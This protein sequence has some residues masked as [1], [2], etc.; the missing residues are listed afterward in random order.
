MRSLFFFL[1]AISINCV[2]QDI[3]P[4]T[5]GPEYV[6]YYPENTFIKRH[7][8]KYVIDSSESITSGKCRLRM[9]DTLGRIIIDNWRPDAPLDNPFIYREA[10]DTTYRLKYNSDKS[11][12]IAYERFVHNKKGQIVSYLDCANYYFKDNSYYVQYEAFYYD[13]NNILQTRLSYIREEFPGKVADQANVKPTDLEL[14][15]VINYS[16]RTLKNGHKLK[17]GKHALGKPDWRATDTTIFD[18]QNRMIR[19]NSFSKRGVTG[20]LIRNLLNNITV[21]QYTDSTLKITGY[22]T[23]C[24]FFDEQVGCLGSLDESHKDEELFIYNRDKL[25]RARYMNY[26]S[27]EPFL[28]DKYSYTYY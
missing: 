23:F 13:E 17:I 21:Y 26:I 6:K 20:E 3:D 25:P 15:D 28:I 10:G 8:I 5:W 16:Y 18:K 27:G 12:L 24:Q 14:Y 19:F 1:L 2:A 11:S 22:R 4:I 7:R 9:Y